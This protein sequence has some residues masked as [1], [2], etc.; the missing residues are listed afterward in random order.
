M[1]P[2]STRLRVNTTSVSPR[3]RARAEEPRHQHPTSASAR[4]RGSVGFLAGSRDIGGSA[5]TGCSR[6][7]GAGSRPSGI[8]GH[9]SR[10]RS[11]TGHVSEPACSW[12]LLNRSGARRAS[13][14]ADRRRLLHELSPI[15][16]RIA[17][18]GAQIV[19]PRVTWR[20]TWGHMCHPV[21]LQVTLN[22]TNL[23]LQD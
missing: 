10:S 14:Q 19:T 16:G 21:G 12:P 5:R 22:G 18:H 8:T 15:P 9:R 3:P 13:F 1:V 2:R 11:A 7:P 6:C 23:T 20:P 4:S 17:F